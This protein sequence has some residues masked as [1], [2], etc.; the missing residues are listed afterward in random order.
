MRCTQPMGLTE[1]AQRLVQGEQVLAY[2]EQ[3]VRV[4]PDG[5]TEPAPDRPVY[6]STVKQ[7]PS[8]EM[9]N[10]IFADQGEQYPLHKYTLPNGTVYYERVQAE[11]WHSGPVIFLA[12][13]DEEG[14]WVPE[15]L[16]PEEVL[17]TV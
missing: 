8:G 13:Q 12:L 10:G 11:P 15:S 1:E 9:F 17:A 5:R 14:S 7:E 3:V 16:W 2:T 6:V 4:Y